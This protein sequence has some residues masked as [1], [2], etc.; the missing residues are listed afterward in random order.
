[1]TRTQPG[2][3]MKYLLA[4]LDEE[5]DECIIWPF[6]KDADG[7]GV[8][9][10][11]QRAHILACTAAHGPRPPGLE[12]LH[13]CDNSSCFNKRHVRWGTRQE[14]EDEKTARGRR[15]MKIT[16]EQ[17]KAI[18]ADKRTTRVIAAEYGI[19][20]IQVSLIKRGRRR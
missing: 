5:T 12:V 4:H 1:M 11:N 20:S 9:P 13:S 16:A 2:E 19:S 6:G 14:N 17:A 3:P 15:P 7:Y 8:V 10:R 18:Q